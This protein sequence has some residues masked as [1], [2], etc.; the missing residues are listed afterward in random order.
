[1]DRFDL[2]FYDRGF[3]ASITEFADKNIH[4]KQILYYKD[5]NIKSV[6]GYKNGLPDGPNR[7]Y[8]QNGDLVAEKFFKNG[9]LD[10]KFTKF[11]NNKPWS[12]QHYK[13]NRPITDVQFLEEL[14]TGKPK[15]YVF[16]PKFS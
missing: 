15:S 3:L 13:H 7:T 6:A 5:G 14:P 4:G 1:M 9:E 8:N 11:K 10:G 12:I 2:Y 16:I